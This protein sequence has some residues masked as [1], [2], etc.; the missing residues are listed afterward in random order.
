MFST[1]LQKDNASNICLLGWGR[2]ISLSPLNPTPLFCP[3]SRSLSL[4]LALSLSLSLF[5]SLSLSN[6][7]YISL[8]GTC[9]L[10][11]LRCLCL[12]SSL[13]RA[14]GRDST[15]LAQSLQLMPASLYMI[16]TWAICNPDDWSASQINAQK[17]HYPPIRE[18]ARTCTRIPHRI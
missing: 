17:A 9:S 16:P 1:F 6:S 18:H 13:Y 12:F 15:R 10:D 14:S 3:C 5:L 8:S 4:S 2:Q 11:G 7:R